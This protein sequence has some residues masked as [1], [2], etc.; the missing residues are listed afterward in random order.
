MTV[1]GY[2]TTT[3]GF[4]MVINPTW[5]SLRGYVFLGTVVAR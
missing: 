3:F 5:A 2:V 1:I 4:G